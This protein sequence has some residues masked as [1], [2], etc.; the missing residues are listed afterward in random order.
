MAYG[1]H[2]MD[3]P[4]F[5]NLLDLRTFHYMNLEIRTRH[6]PSFNL[7]I[8][9]IVLL[10]STIGAS[11]WLHSMVAIPPTVIAIIIILGALKV[12]LVITYYMEINHAPIWLKMLCGAWVILVF[13]TILFCYF[14]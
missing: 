2:S 9:W 13:G 11:L 8:V 4:F 5:I 3:C 6:T 7:V 14:S 12:T 1:R 10:I